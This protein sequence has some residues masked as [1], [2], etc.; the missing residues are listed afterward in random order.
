MHRRL[1]SCTDRS[2]RNQFMKSYYCSSRV[3]LNGKVLYLAT[4][5][6]TTC[7]IHLE[8]VDRKTKESS[9]GSS[10]ITNRELMKRSRFPIY[11]FF[12][13]NVCTLR[14]SSHSNCSYNPLYMH[15]SPIYLSR[16]SRTGSWILM[17]PWNWSMV[18]NRETFL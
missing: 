1:Y 10:E 16:T 3:G 13:I 9:L 7:L 2:H 6:S 5:C 8:I 12:N 11:I 14:D 4:L 17:T 18:W 15:G